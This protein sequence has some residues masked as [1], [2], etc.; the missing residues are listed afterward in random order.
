MQSTDYRD[1]TLPVAQRVENLLAQMTVGEKVAQLS[2]TLGW[3]AYRRT[4]NGIE[5]TE[6]GKG[7]LSGDGIGGLYGLLRADPWTGVTAKTGLS[8]EEGARLV[9]EIQA[10]IKEH[11]RFGIPVFVI[12]E[13]NHGYMALGGTLGPSLLTASQSWNPELWRAFMAAARQEMRAQGNS[14]AFCPNIDLGRDPRWG[15]IEETTGEDPFLASIFADAAVRGLQGSEVGPQSIAACLKHLVHGAPESGLNTHASHMGRHEL[16]EVFLRPFRAGIRAGAAGVMPSYNEIDGEPCSGSQWLLTEV[17][18]KSLGFGGVAFSDVAA[19]GMLVSPFRR[20][21]S[22]EEAAALSLEAGIDFESAQTRLY[23]EPLLSALESGL[24]RMEQIERS[25][26]RVLTLKFKL[27]LFDVAAAD[28]EKATYYMGRDSHRQ[29]ALE[30]AREGIVLLKNDGVL[31]LAKEIGSLAVIGPNAH[32]VYN[33]LGDYSA[34]QRSDETITILGGIRRLVPNIR[35]AYAKGCDIRGSD[36]S[37]FG[38]ALDLARRCAATVLVLGGSSA[39]DFELDDISTPELG[40]MTVDRTSSDIEC[41]EGL[42]RQTLG[43]LGVQ[44]ELAAELAALGK[45]LILVLVCGRPMLLGSLAQSASGI[46]LAGY[47]GQEGGGAVAEVLFGDVNPSGRLTTTWPKSEGQL[48]LNYNSKPHVGNGYL[49]W[50]KDPEF[51]FGYGLSYSTFEYSNLEIQVTGRASVRVSVTV[52]NVSQ[53]PGD[54]VVQLYLRDEVSRLTRPTREL[55]GFHRV[56]LSPSMSRQV[57]FNLQ[58]E[59]LGYYD[60]DG[61]LCLEPGEFSVFVGGGLDSGLSDRFRLA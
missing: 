53:A 14:I 16:N 54:E 46:L 50:P 33:Q 60:G 1:A 20:V 45:P 10:Y 12:A 26:S 41:G 21:S 34:P 36:R 42:D 27:G 37:G 24:V 9:L 15:R 11:T 39:R 28:A 19:L 49:D 18:R 55:K 47:P 40:A 6:V 44:S 17:L 59:E 30:V 32:N 7:W 48:P 57:M 61:R 56:H 3:P 43:L 35:V 25:V 23:D 4:S 51:P 29:L 22:F 31:P 2:A 52:K 58:E 5:I 8:R 38:D 13:A